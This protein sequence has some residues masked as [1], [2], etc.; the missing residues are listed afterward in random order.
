MKV[1]KL[2]ISNFRGI[3][4][5]EWHIPSNFVCLV[6][7]GDST[8]TT[9]LDAIGLALSRSYSSQFTDADFYE[10]D[11][12][13]PIVIE[14]A[15]AELP[16]QL[17]QES[18]F[19]KDRCG[20]GPGGNLEH[21]PIEGTEECLLVRL[22]VDDTL[23]PAWSIVRPGDEDGRPIS[24]SQRQRLGFFRVG[25]YVDRH[26]RWARASALTGMTENRSDAA[27]VVLDAQRMARQA[28][29]KAAP[30]E[31]QE[32]ADIVRK[33][34]RDLG[35]AQYD[36]LRP[37]LDPTSASA[38]HSLVL[39]DGNVPLTRHGLGTRRLTSLS[40]Q[41]EAVEGGSIVAI[42]EIEHGLE[43]H[44]LA[45]ALRYLHERAD[46][47]HLQVL[48]TTHSPVA[49]SALRAGDLAVVASKDGVTTVQAVPDELDEIQGAVRSGPAALLSKKVIVGEGATEVGFVRRLFTL[50]DKDRTEVRSVTS[51]TAGLAV[52]DGAGGSQASRR[53]KVY[54]ELG[55]PAALVIDNDDT[56]VDAAVSD[57]EAASVRV[58]RW[59]TGRALEDEIVLVL[60]DEQLGELLAAAAEERDDVAVRQAVEA[61]LS[62]A[63]LTG[64][65][66]VSWIEVG[67]S[68]DAVRAAIASA[69][70][71]KKL[72]G[73]EKDGAKAWFKRESGGERLAE[74]VVKHWSTVEN[75][76]LGKQLLALQENIYAD[77]PGVSESG[78][79]P[80]HG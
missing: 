42:D 56:G 58:I 75:T 39:H 60:S 33:R 6:G 70:Q 62:G 36:G 65:D 32:T 35:S 43:P 67:A 29:F 44:R 21:D 4:A 46:T 66:P 40:I 73:E 53:A 34:A 78:A 13:T 55:Y 74:L 71:G 31:L 50:W 63:Q 72:N 51:V 10:C 28:V 25:E 7:P 22:T 19:G 20:I 1:R 61:R 77:A 52:V 54:A 27:S 3:R 8:K 15:V 68:R 80:E 47:S 57:A 45:H 18:T 9:L 12:A 14:V 76:D 2:T 5:C 30:Q 64:L 38:A 79:P 48:L 17:V 16:D 59:A 26:L 41:E 69:A 37:G 23:E 24:A 49:V 11:I